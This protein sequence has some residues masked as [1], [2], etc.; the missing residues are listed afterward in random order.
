MYQQTKFKHFLYAGDVVLLELDTPIE[1][2]ETVTA[3]CLS[4]VPINKEDNSC[5]SVGWY[6]AE[7]K[8]NFSINLISIIS[9]RTN[10]L[11]FVIFYS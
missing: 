9:N 5:I 8:L 6:A 11:N 1:F 7:G 4:D 2:S 3:A 10:L